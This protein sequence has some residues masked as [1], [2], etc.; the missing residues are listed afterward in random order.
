[1]TEANAGTRSKNG[2]SKID[3]AIKELQ[4]HLKKFEERH[5]MKYPFAP[6]GKMIPD[7]LFIQLP[8]QEPEEDD[9]EEPIPEPVAPEDDDEEPGQLTVDAPPVD[10]LSLQS[11]RT[12]SKVPSKNEGSSKSK[13]ESKIV[14][15]GQKH[16]KNNGDESGN[17]TPRSKIAQ[18]LKKTLENNKK[19]SM[20]HSDSSAKLTTNAKRPDVE[21]MSLES[22][23]EEV[24][25]LRAELS[26]QSQKHKA[27]M[28]AEKEKFDQLLEN[29]KRDQEKIVKE[30][31]SKIREEVMERHANILQ[32]AKRKQWCSYC[33]KE[34]IY[35]CCWNTSYCSADCQTLHW[36]VHMSS[37]QQERVSQESYQSDA[38]GSSSGHNG[39]AN[40]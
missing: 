16:S 18:D 32:D 4:E 11:S 30:R 36:S 15:S 10:T 12:P 28:K 9:E 21:T 25:S 13:D 38:A 19:K 7:K 37:C 6:E 27:M 34:A 17:K 22:M 3:V 33:L 23:K 24:R 14:T 20:E 26:L 8:G 29:I 2:K 40:P 39:S 31:T 5:G 1:M 35:Y